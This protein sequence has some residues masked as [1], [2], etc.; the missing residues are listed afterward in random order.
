MQIR[1]IAIAPVK[2]LGLSHPDAVEL[3]STGVPEDRRYALIDARGR[4]ANGKR[5][6]PLVAVRASCALN[7]ETLWLTLPDGTR[8]SGEVVTGEPIEALFY[9]RPRPARVVLGD[10]SAALSALAGEPLR[11]VRMPDG[12]AIDRVGSGAVSLLTSASLTELGRAAGAAGAV[13][14]R[15]FRMTFTVSGAQ[16]HAEDSW[17]GR[18]VRIGTA[19][20]VP[21]G[22]IGRCAVTMQDPD[23]GIADLDTLKAI[24]GYRDQ[25]PTTEKLPFGVHARVVEPGRAGVGDQVELDS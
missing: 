8:V 12:T 7:P 22:H 2:G 6:G 15:R 13:D 19:I 17:V 24:A 25:L 21:E 16:P 20:V 9:G 4:L 23:T 3:T 1:Q 5:F 14:A 18:R 10:Y 11:L